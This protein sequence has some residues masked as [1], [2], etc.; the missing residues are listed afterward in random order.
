MKHNQSSHRFNLV[1]YLDKPTDQS[2]IEEEVDSTMEG[3][4][5]E[6]GRPQPLK[7]IQF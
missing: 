7:V 2:L 6:N 1:R 5:F 3:N 4:M